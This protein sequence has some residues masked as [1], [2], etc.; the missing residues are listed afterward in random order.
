MAFDNPIVQ[1]GPFCLDG[2]YH[3]EEPTDT[4]LTEY[5]VNPADTDDSTEWPWS[6]GRHDTWNTD[7]GADSSREYVKNVTFPIEISFPSFPDEDTYISQVRFAYQAGADF[8]LQLDYDLESVYTNGPGF[9]QNIVRM[10]VEV[11]G[12]EELNDNDVQYGSSASISGTYEISLPA[13]VEPIIVIVRA[14]YINSNTGAGYMEYSLSKQE[15][16]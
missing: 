8:T 4:F 6:Y 16:A 7:S 13:T 9:D 11:D 15:P 2:D 5:P 12:V 10:V 1:A 3:L 14:T